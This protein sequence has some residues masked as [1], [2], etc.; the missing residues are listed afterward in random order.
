MMQRD[1]GFSTIDGVFTPA[2]MSQALHGLSIADLDRTKAGAR[3]VLSVSVVR[4][5][6]F[7]RRLVQIA[8]QFVGAGATPFR[9]TLFDKSGQA[10]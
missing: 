3:H 4:Q 7:D 1:Q 6:A 8:R 2:D 10:N 5:L 9:A